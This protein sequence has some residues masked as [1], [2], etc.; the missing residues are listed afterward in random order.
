MSRALH[1][2]EVETPRVLRREATIL[3]HN[4][5]R[6]SAMADEIEAQLSERPLLCGKAIGDAAADVLA[7]TGEDMHYLELLDAV[8]RATG[9]RVR[10]AK[11]DCTLL[12]NV[13]RHPLIES[14]GPR[15]GRYRFVGLSGRVYTGAGA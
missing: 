12:A 5:D 8:E 2:I 3:R 7:A 1:T 9:K 14:C 4:A 6:L 10:G 13:G 15:S 11:P